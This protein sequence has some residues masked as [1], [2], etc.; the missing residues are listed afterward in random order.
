LDFRSPL[1][2]LEVLETS[3]GALGVT[4]Q[5]R[6][7]GSLAPFYEAGSCQVKFG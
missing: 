4:I 2:N 7:F 3:G 1:L 6:I 5:R